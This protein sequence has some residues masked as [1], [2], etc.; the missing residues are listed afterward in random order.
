MRLLWKLQATFLK[1]DEEGH[2]NQYILNRF[3]KYIENPKNRLHVDEHL[4]ATPN[5]K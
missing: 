4:S 2:A 5:N 1:Q 3:L